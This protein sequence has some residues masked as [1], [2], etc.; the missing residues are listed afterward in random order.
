MERTILLLALILLSNYSFGQI[1][2]LDVNQSMLIQPEG[3]SFED[4]LFYK[5][6]NPAEFGSQNSD[7]SLGDQKPFNGIMVDYYFG[8]KNVSWAMECINGKT[9]TWYK[10]YYKSGQISSEKRLD[11]TG[12]I[13]GPAKE[14]SESGKLKASGKYKN[15]EKHGDWEIWLENGKLERVEKYN[16]GKLLDE[17]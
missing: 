11:K 2:T 12:M 8:T 14:W 9:T 7:E 1:D 15:G 10:S 16:L 3:S 13:S 17:Y 4:A 6:D 5:N